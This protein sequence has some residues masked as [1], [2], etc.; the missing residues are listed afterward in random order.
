MTDN[1]HSNRFIKICKSILSFWG[2]VFGELLIY[3]I[4]FIIGLFIVWLFDMDFNDL[5][6]ESIVTL[7]TLVGFIL[8]GIVALVVHWV[9]KSNK[10]QKT[11]TYISIPFPLTKIL[12]HKYLVRMTTGRPYIIN[13]EILCLNYTKNHY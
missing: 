13:L 9:R 11:I 8:M 10:N 7:I 12:T 3:M 2:E 5:D 1:K 4:A 6:S